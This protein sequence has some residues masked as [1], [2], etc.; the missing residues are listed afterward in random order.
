MKK[1]CAMTMA[2]NDIFFLEKWIEHYGK[3]FGKE[4]LYVFLDGLDQELPKNG[5]DVN[6]RLIEHQEAEM[7]R[8]D[9]I[10]ISFLNQQATE[11][12]KK[13]DLVIGMDVDEFLV[14]DPRC[15][16]TLKSYLSQIKCKSCVSGLGVDVGHK[17]D[18]EDNI[19][20]SKPFLSQ[21]SYALIDSQYTKPVIISKPVKWG[22]GFHRVKYH[23]Y[24]IDKN[25]Y[26]F[27]F[28]SV[29]SEIMKQKLEDK[30]KITFGWS[31][32]LEQR[33]RTISLVSN[34][35]ALDGNIYLPIAR[36]LQT[37]IRH[38][39]AWFRP[40]MYYWKLIIKIPERFRS[41]V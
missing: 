36:F 1:I 11:L 12:L 9:R 31:K 14:V 21:R 13:Y 17:L 38:P 19:D 29:D 2:R 33:Y 15:K 37:I 5:K 10:R 7:T 18:E 39:F 40:Y 25:L 41:E 28:G 4:N 6:I 35:K 26:L 23:N 8:G 30:A 3:S 32:H 20:A 22:A 34:K 16:S 24:R 27:H